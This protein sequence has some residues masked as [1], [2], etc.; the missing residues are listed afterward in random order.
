VRYQI[1]TRQGHSVIIKPDSSGERFEA[2]DLTVNLSHV[3]LITE[4]GKSS[5]LPHQAAGLLH[6]L[7][8]RALYAFDHLHELE[9]EKIAKT[10]LLQS[11]LSFRDERLP[12]LLHEIAREVPTDEAALKHILELTKQPARANGLLA[13]VV[14]A[15]DSQLP[16]YFR[17]ERQ[18]GV[19]SWLESG[20]TLSLQYGVGPNLRLPEALSEQ[21]RQLLTD[22]SINSFIFD[23]DTGTLHGSSGKM[24]TALSVLTSLCSTGT[25]GQEVV[26]LN[27]AALMRKVSAPLRESK[28]LLNGPDP[29]AAVEEVLSSQVETPAARLLSYTCMTGTFAALLRASVLENVAREAIGAL[30]L[31]KV[32][33]ATFM[34]ERS[35][36]FFSLYRQAKSAIHELAVQGVEQ[37]TEFHS[38]LRKQIPSLRVFSA[39]WI[40]HLTRKSGGALQH[41][42][43]RDAGDLL[44]A[45]DSAHDWLGF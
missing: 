25:L 21:G 12:E 23:V 11:L 4:P 40:D 17:P 7:T 33:V 6:P 16:G 35:L 36:R 1:D 9:P 27:Q 26:D 34:A 14:Q 37:L 31:F 2:S 39:T 29:V 3:A 8:V 18:T 38:S 24:P 28:N 41:Y 42:P 5:D 45:S 43:R 20:A 19:W 22:F 30:D 44:E 10:P 32:V 15:I 13:K